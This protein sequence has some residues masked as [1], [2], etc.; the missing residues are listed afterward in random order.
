MGMYRLLRQAVPRRLLLKQTDRVVSSWR[1][2]E[3]TG[4]WSDFGREVEQLR[5]LWSDLLEVPEFARRP[6]RS[7]I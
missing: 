3:R 2:G 5:R 6:P 4:R 7:G 1:R